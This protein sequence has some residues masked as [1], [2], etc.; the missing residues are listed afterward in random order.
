MNSLIK[1]LLLECLYQHLKKVLV[2]F[3]NVCKFHKN[4]RRPTHNSYN[5]NKK[6]LIINHQLVKIIYVYTRELCGWVWIGL[7]E[8]CFSSIKN[9]NL[10]DW[11]FRD[12]YP[13][14]CNIDMQLN[15]F[16]FV[17][18][19]FMVPHW[20]TYLPSFLVFASVMSFF[21]VFFLLY[22]KAGIAEHWNEETAHI[23]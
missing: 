1:K 18:R 8:W 20:H 13:L 3:L 7:L 17:C 23:K 10:V 15:I 9:E 21:Y 22:F 14:A 12:Y 11:H 6:K 5:N 2:Y 16:Y 19:F 4:M